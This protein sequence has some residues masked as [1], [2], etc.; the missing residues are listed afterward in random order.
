MDRRFMEQMTPPFPYM[1]CLK[2]MKR[3]REIP[4][5]LR[6]V[7]NY[8]TEGSLYFESLMVELPQGVAVVEK[9]SENLFE[10][11]SDEL[12]LELLFGVEDQT[13]SSQL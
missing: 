11:D 12:Q 7:M 1:K 8:L 3:R 4:T 9:N 6:R 13:S 2:L 10:D 5:V